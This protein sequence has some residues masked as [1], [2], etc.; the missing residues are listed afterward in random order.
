MT[1]PRLVK[2]EI[3]HRGSVR[4]LLTSKGPCITIFLPGIRPGEAEPS[5]AALMKA[6]LRAAHEELLH[7]KI[8][9]ADAANLLEPLEDPAFA[10]SS[11]ESRV[12]FRAPDLLEQFHLR[13]AAAASAHVGACF[14]IRPL[15]AELALPESFYILSL[16]KTRVALYGRS[17]LDFERV[18]LGAGVSEELRAFTAFDPPDHRLENR[19][20]AGRSAGNIAGVP[21]GTGAGQEREKLHLADF[22]K[23]IDRAILRLDREAKT[24][25]LLAGVEEE[26]SMYQGISLNPNLMKEIIQGS[27]NGGR[28]EASMIARAQEILRA[29]FLETKAA[30]LRNA[31]E[32]N[33]PAK[34]VNDFDSIIRA[35][36]EGRVAHLYLNNAAEKLGVFHRDAY[37][38][39]SPEDLWNVAAVQTLLHK[40]E[41]CSLPPG[42][43]PSGLMAVAILR[44]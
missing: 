34:V 31:K 35:A 13:Q 28:D 3:M 12:I 37:R 20:A 43:F 17:G 40:G 2:P 38:S 16:S 30:E 10:A 6:N 7:R 33:D 42:T 25:L 14:S 18:S 8:S 26:T 4:E 44:Y 21:F 23:T 24:P 19:S 41:V 27:L 5:S 1:T 32:T 11:H 36:F 22:F 9:S 15:L 29:D 39:M